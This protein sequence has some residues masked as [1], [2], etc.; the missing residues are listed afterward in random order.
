LVERDT[1][2]G[3]EKLLRRFLDSMRQ[4]VDDGVSHSRAERD[5]QLEELSEAVKLG[6]MDEDASERPAADRTG[7]NAEHRVTSVRGGE[8]SETSDGGPREC[9]LKRFAIGPAAR[10][11]KGAVMG[12]G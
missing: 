7:G 8:S 2:E 11:L 4:E 10:R 12:D 1:E 3:V 6:K 5:R 9:Y